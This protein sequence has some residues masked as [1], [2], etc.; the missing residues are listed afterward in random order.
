MSGGGSSATGARR[1]VETAMIHNGTTLMVLPIGR[2]APT[3]LRLSLG[4]LAINV[5]LWVDLVLGALMWRGALEVRRP[6][7]KWRRVL[8]RKTRVLVRFDPCLGKI[9]GGEHPETAHDPKLEPDSKYKSRLCSPESMRLHV[10]HKR[11]LMGRVGRI[12]RKEMFPSPRYGDFVYNTVASVGAPD[13]RNLGAYTNPNSPWFNVFLGYYQIDVSIEEWG[14]PFGYRDDAGVQSEIEFEDIVRLGKADWN[15]F[16]NWMYGV[17]KKYLRDYAAIDMN[18]VSCEEA[19]TTDRTTGEQIRSVRGCNSRV[20]HFL[21]MHGVE[22]ASSYESSASRAAKLV[23]NTPLWR[24]WRDSFGLPNPQRGQDESFIPTT[25]HA[26]FYMAYRR[27][28]DMFHTMM[29]GG[30]V[31]VD[32]E[33]N[34][35]QS[36][37]DEQLRALERVISEFYWQ[38]GFELPPPGPDTDGPVAQAVEGRFSSMALASARAGSEQSSVKPSQTG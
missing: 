31:L 35:D 28:E 36:F 18:A 29:F 33:G 10:T 11:R 20:W 3:V 19:K 12:V 22:V 34:W 38:Y 21:T 2:D 26:Q 24:V 7:G 6:G 25:M 9:G 13:E 5:E 14:R 16:S 27:N 1:E 15:W 37:L 32:K 4:V 8:G 17:P 23:T 30:T